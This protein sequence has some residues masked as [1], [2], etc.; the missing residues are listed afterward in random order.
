[1]STG[2]QKPG[3]TESLLPTSLVSA[4][5]PPPPPSCLPPFTL[6]PPA[7]PSPSQSFLRIHPS[8]SP[9]TP[10]L[11]E[12]WAG[13]GHRQEAER[14]TGHWEVQGWQGVW[15]GR[16]WEGGGPRDCERRWG[17]RRAPTRL[18]GQDPQDDW[19]G[20]W[21]RQDRDRR[22]RASR[23][24]ACPRRAPHRLSAHCPPDTQT[25]CTHCPLTRAGPITLPPSPS[26][27]GTGRGPWLDKGGEVGG[28]IGPGPESPAGW[29][30]LP[31]PGP[32]FT[33]RGGRLHLGS[34][35][36]GPPLS[37]ASHPLQ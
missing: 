2:G 21:H 16:G 35:Q 37:L 24:D 32:G 26:S 8:L 22:P 13:G 34:Q 29:P 30:S 23:G 9:V 12:Q 19:G 7:D 14:G 3:V 5:F 4:L 6:L 28:S 33:L 1:M 31:A 27:L 18:G 36:A 15:G 17:P 11:R 20:A 25:P 10:P